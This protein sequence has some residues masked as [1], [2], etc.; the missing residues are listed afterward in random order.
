MLCKDCFLGYHFSFSNF[1]EGASAGEVTE[2]SGTRAEVSCGHNSRMGQE[3]REGDLC[4]EKQKLGRGHQS[5][6]CGWGRGGHFL[7][8]DFIGVVRDQTRYQKPGF[9]LPLELLPGSEPNLVNPSTKKSR[10]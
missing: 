4:G 9:P 6:N 5:D 3:A 7:G 2:E 1:K 10:K 8:K